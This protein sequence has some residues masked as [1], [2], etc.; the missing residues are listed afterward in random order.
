M[1]LIRCSYVYA[2]EVY[3]ADLFGLVCSRY[4][5]LTDSSALE[6]EKDLK[7]TLIPDKENKTLTIRDSG[8]GSANNFFLA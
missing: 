4:A 1:R 8:I 5:A 2:L 6:T 7:I 3:V